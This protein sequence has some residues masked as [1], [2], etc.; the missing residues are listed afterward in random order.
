MRNLRFCQTIR[1]FPGNVE[2]AAGLKIALGTVLA[3]LLFV[4]V[5]VAQTGAAPITAQKTPHE[6]APMK[7]V[8]MFPGGAVTSANWSGYAVTGS[9]FT[10]AKGSW[11]VPE[12]DCNKTPDR[13]S[14]FW[15]GLDGY[16]DSTVEQTGTSSDCDGTT[17]VYYAWYEFYPAGSVTISMAVAPGDVMGA[18][19]TYSDGKFTLGLHNHTTGAEF[20]VTKAVSGAKRTSAEWIAEAP[21][22][23]GGILPLADFVRA[24]YGEDYNSDADTNYATD[25]VVTDGPIIDFGA[26]YHAITMVNG[27]ITYS[28]PTALTADGTSFRVFWKH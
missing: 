25:K 12:V 13:Y 2:N 27:G 20:H 8:G 24:S 28:K 3:L 1:R 19:V 9:E 15:L 22:G 4:G 16:S 23:S 18:S 21:S 14:A 6:H 5:G 7:L 10:Y 17:P 11:H 26:D